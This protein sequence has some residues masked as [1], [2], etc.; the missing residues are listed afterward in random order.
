MVDKTA[1]CPLCRGSGLVNEQ[2]VSWLVRQ[3]NYILSMEGYPRRRRIRGG[4]GRIKETVQV[5]NP[6]RNHDTE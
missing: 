1:P 5:Q 3:L 6:R 2:D 4:L